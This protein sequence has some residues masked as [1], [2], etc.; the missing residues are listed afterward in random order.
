MTEHRILVVDDNLMSR[1]VLTQHL[2]TMG[3]TRIVPVASAAEAEERLLDSHERGEPFH[4]ML[5]DWHMPGE[6]GCRFL[7]KCREDARFAA[8]PIIMATAENDPKN[9][10]LAMNKGATFYIV[11]PVSYADLKKSVFQALQKPAPSA[12]RPT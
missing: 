11:K 9:V 1:K 12:R 7:I 10:R 4:L 6:D 3:F 2:A 5:L 8:L